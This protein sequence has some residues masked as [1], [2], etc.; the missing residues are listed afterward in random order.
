MSYKKNGYIVYHSEVI[1][2]YSFLPIVIQTFDGNLYEKKIVCKA[3]I[4]V[5][6]DNQKYILCE[7]T[8]YFPKFSEKS[9]ITRS[10]EI[11]VFEIYKPPEL[12]VSKI[13]KEKQ[14]LIDRYFA[15]IQHSQKIGSLFSYYQVFIP[16]IKHTY[17]YLFSIYQD[18]ITFT[19]YLSLTND[20]KDSIQHQV[21]TSDYV[22]K[23]V[24]EIEYKGKHKVILE[25]DT[26]VENILTSSNNQSILQDQTIQDHILEYN[27]TDESSNFAKI[28][29]SYKYHLLLRKYL[30]EKYMVILRP[31]KYEEYIDLYAPYE[32]HILESMWKSH[33]T[34]I[35]LLENEKH[36][37]FYMI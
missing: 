22:E 8:H 23:R 9:F 20:I 13:Y 27:I 16:N 18:Q 30:K 32:D 21:Y 37:S 35:E 31:P 25:D 5:Y 12:V 24:N 17:Q 14:L 7:G 4:E 15:D 29:Y 26:I 6:Y 3:K 19:K 34:V 36:I 28:K 2:N 10:K 33:F 11:D 1:P